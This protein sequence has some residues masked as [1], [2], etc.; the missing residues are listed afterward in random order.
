LLKQ[1]DELLKQYKKILLK[2]LLKWNL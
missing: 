2:E 1:K